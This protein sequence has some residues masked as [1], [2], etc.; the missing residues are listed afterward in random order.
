M[1]QLI[2][3][4]RKRLGLLVYTHKSHRRAAQWNVGQ[5]RH[6]QQNTIKPQINHESVL[7]LTAIG[8]A[9]DECYRHNRRRKDWTHVDP[10]GQG[11]AKP[12]KHEQWFAV[13]KL[14]EVTSTVSTQH[15]VG[16]DDTRSATVNQKAIMRLP[17][18]SPTLTEFFNRQWICSKD[19][20]S[21]K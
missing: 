4:V 12:Q 21:H 2:V 17:I 11:C 9:I 19:T 15:F 8:H 18:I 16:I 7:R 13:K 1:H 3:R 5:A 14:P 10:L 6:T 20:N